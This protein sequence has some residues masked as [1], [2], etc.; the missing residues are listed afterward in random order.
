MSLTRAQM[1]AKIRNDHTFATLVEV[2]GRP[3]A[4][5]DCT[6]DGRAGDYCMVGNWVPDP[7][8][9]KKRLVMKC[10]ES[11]GCTVYKVVRC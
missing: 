10:D 5:K 2:L 1:N 6:L 11:N 4:V 8:G 3:D 9:G 7:R